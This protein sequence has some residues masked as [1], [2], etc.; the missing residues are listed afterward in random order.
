M[1]SR[2]NSRISNP[3]ELKAFEKVKNIYIGLSSSLAGGNDFLQDFVIHYTS[4]LNVDKYR[5]CT[6]EQC[7]NKIYIYLLAV[8]HKIFNT[9][10]DR[11]KLRMVVEELNI[12]RFYNLCNLNST[13]PH[14]TGKYW[15]D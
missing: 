2:Q 4:K 1:Y 14:L 7:V 6:L 10:K 11:K 8:A 13:Y 5:K 9:P 12:I 15:L 3:K